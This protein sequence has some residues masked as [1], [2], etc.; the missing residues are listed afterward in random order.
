[1]VYD[2]RATTET[3][4]PA[5]RDASNMARV[6]LSANDVTDPSV[7]VAVSKLDTILDVNDVLE[8]Q[9]AGTMG[10]QLWTDFEAT[11]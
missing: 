4:N 11:R 2:P 10:E 9:V 8:T 3:F 6:I 5:P 1:M 7:A